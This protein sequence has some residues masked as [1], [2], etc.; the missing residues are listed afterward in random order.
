MSLVQPWRRVS[1]R[2]GDA[3]VR[4]VELPEHIPLRAVLLLLAVLGV[5]VIGLLLLATWRIRCQRLRLTGL[6]AERQQVL[7]AGQDL[8][9]HAVKQPMAL[10]EAWRQE[11]ES[12][13]QPAVEATAVA[14]AAAAP[15][16]AKTSHPAT[17]PLA[18]AAVSAAV[19]SVRQHL[20]ALAA[21][22]DGE[23]FEAAVGL[24]PALSELERRLADLAASP[25]TAT[26]ATLVLALRHGLETQAWLHDIFRAEII[27]RTLA[28]P[29]AAWSQLGIAMGAVAALARASL[30]EAGIEVVLPTLLTPAGRGQEIADEGASRLHRVGIFNQAVRS[31][32]GS[33]AEPGNIIV[34]CLKVGIRMA[35]S[36]GQ[37]ARIT[38]PLVVLYAPM[39]WRAPPS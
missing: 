26:P 38:P 12:N 11:R 35:P 30:A 22:T 24:G 14:H 7:A 33:V 19:G 17:L 31:A 32:L 36:H 9:G 10:L 4:V 18:V 3:V 39:A 34:D 28:A 15:T 21:T 2:I 25:A 27:L 29:G 20:K 6:L 5:L 23:R 13:R 37:A 8:L 1:A 16:L